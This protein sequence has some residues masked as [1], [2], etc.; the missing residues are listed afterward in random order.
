[1]AI[2]LKIIFLTFLLFVVLA[3]CSSIDAPLIKNTQDSSIT[4][5]ESFAEGEGK[6]VTIKGYIIGQPISNSTVVRKEFPNDY[7][8]AIADSREE[9]DL[10]KMLFVQITE[11][12]RASY[13]LQSNS[14]LQGSKITVT[15]HLESYFSHP[16]L[17]SISSIEVNP[18][19]EEQVKEEDK[20]NDADSPEITDPYYQA[21]AGK[22]G[23]ELKT[24]LHEIIDD[25]I[26]LSYGEVWDAL[27]LTDE[28]PENPDNVLLFYTGRSQSKLLNGGGADDWNREH[29]WARSHGGFGTSKGAGTDLHH[30]RPTDT[31]V[32]SSR[33]NLDFD[34]GGSPHQEAK[35]NFSD[36]DSWEPRN[37]VKGD[38]ARMLFYMAVRYEGDESELDL[39]LNDKV[40][41]KSIPFHGK[42]SV[43]LKWHEMDPVDERERR[44]NDLIFEEFQGNR[45][46]FIDQPAFAE[47]IW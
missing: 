5:E 4:V 37:E 20:G 44:R 33:S 1:M 8:L 28:D 16:G 24:A 45:N 13:G 42:V 2:K 39:E 6:E 22:T 23:N 32:N 11:E 29:V 17:K 25:H 40:D 38:T 27:R 12:F 21:A 10:S 19:K 7:A 41:N 35:G 36:T 34:N 47:M 3:G 14:S 31:T 15:G 46:P 43:L 9:T 30:L 26:T 18:K